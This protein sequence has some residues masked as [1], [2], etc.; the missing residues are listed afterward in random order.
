MVLA[1]LPHFGWMTSTRN[2][3][4]SDSDLE[5]DA[6]DIPKMIEKLIGLCDVVSGWRR[7]RW[8]GN[9]LLENYLQF[10]QTG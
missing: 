8:K 10:A 9:G 4:V 2:I 1:K 5:N 7:R 3:I 6:N